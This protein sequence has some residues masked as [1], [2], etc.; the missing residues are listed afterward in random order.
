MKS[1][2]VSSTFRDM[3][4]ER[5]ILNRRIGSKLNYELSKYNRSVRISDLRWGVDTT[6][7]SEQEASE[8]VL[9]VCIDEIDNCMPYM[10]VLLGDRYGYIPNESNISVT[11]MEIIRGALENMQKEHVFIY[12]R[13]ADYTG[14]PDE[15]CNV[16][17]EQNAEAGKRLE[18]LKAELLKKMPERCFEYHSVWSEKEQLMVSNDFEQLV[19]EHLK[20]D[21]VDEIA[22]V[23]YVSELQRQLV[24]NEELLS[25]IL[26]SAY[27]NADH[28]AEF[29]RHTESDS[30]PH[31][32]IGQTG[33][34]KS[35]YMSLLCSELQ[36]QEIKAYIAFCGDNA[37]SASVRNSAEFVFYALISACGEKYD[38]NKNAN[39][40]YEEL[41]KNIAQQA[42]HLSEKI[43]VFFDAVDKCDDGMVDF[44]LWCSRFVGKKICIVFSS[45]LL[46][47]IAEYRESFDLIDIEHTYQ[48][49]SGMI[50]CLLKMHGKNLTGELIDLICNIAETPL[51]LNVILLR[52]LY[53]NAADFNAI[54][55]EGGGIDAINDYLR[56]IIKKNSADADGIIADYVQVLLEESQN[57]DFD[58]IVLSLI[59]FNAFGLY[60]TD[61]QNLFEYIDNIKWIQMDY[62]DFLS[63][64]SF[65]I[66]VHA[67]GRLD[68][69]HDALRKTIKQL[70]MS[71]KYTIYS[72]LADYFFKT[73]Q[74]TTIVVNSFFDAAYE[75]KAC[76]QIVDFVLKYKN[77]YG[78][79][80]KDEFIIG[81]NIKECLKKLYLCDKGE[82]F[83]QTLRHCED[84]EEIIYF[85]NTL[86]SALLSSNDYL[87]DALVLDLIKGCMLIPV[88]LAEF[89]VEFTE[90]EFFLCE[91]FIERHNVKQ[92]EVQE[93]MEFC[94]RMIEKKKIMSNTENDSTGDIVREDPI[95]QM[96]NQL[97]DDSK[98]MLK[99]TSVFS[100][101]SKIG[102][103]MAEDPQLAVQT[104][105]L[106]KKLVL[107]LDQKD[108]FEDVE[109]SDMLLADIY[110]SFGVLYKSTKQW[111]K[112][113]HYDIESK[114]IYRCLYKKCATDVMLRKY[115][116][117]IYNLANIIE[118][119]AMEKQNDLDV[120]CRACSAYEEVYNLEMIAIAHGVTEREL[121]HCSSA[122]FSYG[123][124][125]IN[126]GHQQEGFMKYK[127]AVG[128]VAE[129]AK[130]NPICDVYLDLCT[131]QL[132]GIYQ[133]SLCRNCKAAEE[134]G[135]ELYKSIGIVA[136]NGDDEQIKEL[137]YFIHCFSDKIND[138]I[139]EL[140]QNQ[141]L[142]NS[143]IISRVLYSVYMAALPIA[144]GIIKSN[145]VLT[146]K[147]IA[148]ILFLKI[149]DYNQA[150]EEYYRLLTDVQEKD[151]LM[152]DEDGHYFDHVNLRLV[153][154]YARALICL[155]KLG[156]NE[157][158]RKM[159]DDVTDWS[160]YL[161]EHSD[162]IRGDNA[163]VLLS[164]GTMLLQNKILDGAAFVMQSFQAINE[165]NY[166]KQKNKSTVLKV[167]KA[168][169]SFLNPDSSGKG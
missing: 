8:R 152:K 155:D 157:D 15:I 55:E 64:F 39:L 132:E 12:F 122:I 72:L 95:E 160:K 83:F 20:I 162:S 151:L 75:A 74:L 106:L 63:R 165:E 96:V 59:S 108:I 51:C 135:Y 48:D 19:S 68:I 117:R 5:D 22:D 25:D 38:F 14:M 102:R 87:D 57:F 10:I 115:R 71:Q 101:L 137:Q 144:E 97:F 140:F 159:L 123:T 143:L 61:L 121:L 54:Q 163:I 81:N 18:Q 130:N 4:F 24:D 169:A 84:L 118:A 58:L 73:A 56:N 53:L 158:I 86:S 154:V 11:H 1:I 129:L 133:L 82:F 120:W 136:E 113:I 45:Q 70:L 44:I 52:L 93:F 99:K 119:Y 110:T 128:I 30:R 42:E 37:F 100:Q 40:S 9:K 141:D 79:F 76:R 16:Y 112:G 28:I 33:T 21:L 167:L 145:M 168:V 124:A 156:R 111:E 80:E 114:E 6:D 116:E 47:K 3:H 91:R 92:P 153:D 134:L 149:M 85:Q 88:K 164:I 35:V 65:F 67:N 139:S 36:R 161:A 125:L 62:V 126:S 31:G 41:L 27:K 46:E 77:F 60:E 34:G 78:S 43:Y 50:N 104:E 127:E 98:D 17:K 103:K 69:S 66:R 105:N 107:A 148:D 89:P 109:I 7:L 49:F 94:K 90:M 146:Q 26:K 23:Q 138:I 2:F 32:I 29:I 166:D 142:E 13:N 150:Y 147:N 131:Q